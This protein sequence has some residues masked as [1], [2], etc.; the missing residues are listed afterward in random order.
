MA[1]CGVRSAAQPLDLLLASK[2][3]GA[4]AAGSDPASAAG[5]GRMRNAAGRMRRGA[6]MAIVIIAL[7]QP[8]ASMRMVASGV[9]II[10]ATPTPIETSETARPRC[11][12]NQAR[13]VA[14]IG[15]PNKPTAAPSR[16]PKDSL[17]KNTSAAWLAR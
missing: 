10:G 7:R 4:A 16:P 3:L 8:L 13:V 6:A 12:S 1:N 9:K 17:K 14:V 5:A 11:L 2:A 15:A